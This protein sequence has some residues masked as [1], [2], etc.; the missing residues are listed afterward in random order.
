MLY[1]LSY[2]G[3]HCNWVLRTLLKARRPLAGDGTGSRSWQRSERIRSG[4]LSRLSTDSGG[5]FRAARSRI[6]C[7]WCCPGLW[8]SIGCAVAGVAMRLLIITIPFA[9]S[10]FRLAIYVLWP[11]GRTVVG[12][13]ML[14]LPRGR[15]RD[16]IHLRWP[17]VG[18]RTPDARVASGAKLANRPT[19]V[20]SMQPIGVEIAR[21]RFHY[22]P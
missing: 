10:S 1:P 22:P 15:Q 3:W 18:Y 7:G 5:C 11:F 21:H 20:T 13:R 12:E 2:E 14:G 4:P 6:C 17:L 8:L 19:A 16:L 9:S